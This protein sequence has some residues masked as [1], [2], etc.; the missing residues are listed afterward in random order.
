MGCGIDMHPGAFAPGQCVRTHFANIV[1]LIVAVEDHRFDLYLDR[2]HARYLGDWFA[3][4][5]DDPL[6]GGVNDP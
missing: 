3:N 4:A 1:L 2:S 6:T 5:G